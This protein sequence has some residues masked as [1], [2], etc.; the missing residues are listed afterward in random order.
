MTDQELEVLLT[1][2]VEMFD[3]KKTAFITLNKIFSDNSENKDFFNGF[4]QDEIITKFDG[5]EYLIDRRHR[6]SIIRTKIGLYVESQDWLDNI[7][8]IGYYELETNL[9]GDVIDDWFV[10][11]KE[12]YLKDIGIISHFQS[13]NENLPIEYLR[14]NHI[15]YEFVSYISMVGTL[16][17]SKQYE[18]TG[19]FIMRAYSN[20]AAVD[21]AKFEK[22]YIKKA[23]V[24]LKMISGYLVKNN[25]LTD[26]LKKELSENKK[27]D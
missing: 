8:P 24:F 21:C 7:E 20:L 17:V 19:R 16:F 26:S 10:I 14:R 4:I 5:F 2:R 27:L 13:M 11:E 6:D 12:K 18:D 3:L 9:N 25:L 23:K 1:E 22:E 15:Q